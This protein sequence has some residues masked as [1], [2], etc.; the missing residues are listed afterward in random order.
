VQLRFDNA[1]EAVAYCERKGIAYQVFEAKAPARRTISYSD[2]FASSAAKP[3]RT[4][5]PSNGTP[6]SVVMPA[7]VAG[8]HD[9]LAVSKT[10]MAGTS[11][12]M[13]ML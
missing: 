13:T 4:K 9:F 5:R 6:I 1:E 3:G 11:P 7:L 2:N 12:A 8:M 10:W